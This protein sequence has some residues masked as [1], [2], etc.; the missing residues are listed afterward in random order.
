MFLTSQVVGK[1]ISDPSTVSR[2]F[3][4]GIGMFSLILGPRPGLLFVTQK[5][6]LKNYVH[7][8]SGHEPYGPPEVEQLVCP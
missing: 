7:S 2:N 3:A 4:K 6:F 1:G 5:T 8:A